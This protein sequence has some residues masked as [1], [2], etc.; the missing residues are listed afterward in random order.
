MADKELLET[1]YSNDI[2]QLNKVPQNLQPKQNLEDSTFWDSFQVALF[3]NKKGSN[4]Y[5]EKLKRHLRQG[6]KEELIVREDGRVEHNPSTGDDI[7]QA[8]KNLSGTAVA[9]IELDHD[10]NNS[11]VKTIPIN[12]VNDYKEDNELNFFFFVFKKKIL[13]V[14][15]RL[16]IKGN[17]N[18]DQDSLV[19]ISIP[20]MV[21]VEFLLTKWW[22]LKDNQ[23]LGNRGSGSM[24]KKNIK[25]MLECFFLNKNRKSQDRMDAQTM[26][27]KLLKYVKAK[28]IEAEDI[29]KTSMIQ[30]WLNTYARAFK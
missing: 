7:S 5:L 8:V 17:I 24:I 1:L 12:D 26:H 20:S 3:S 6:Y 13:I 4:E 19:I 22:A 2:I 15:K 18:V 9:N 11:K 30:N 28:D 16:K 29:P 21:D 25:S 27:D 10:D 14:R 23:K